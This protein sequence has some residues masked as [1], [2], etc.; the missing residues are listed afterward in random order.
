[1]EEKQKT[2]LYLLFKI[3]Q[4]IGP[5]SPDLDLSLVSS[6]HVVEVK[7]HPLPIVL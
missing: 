7:E 4:K 3:F 1:M 2:W 5:V 6:T